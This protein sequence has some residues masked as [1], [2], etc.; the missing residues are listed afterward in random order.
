MA[1]EVLNGLDQGDPYS[2][3]CYLIYN[4]DLTKITVLK[5]GEQILLFVDDAVIIVCSKDF[6]ETHE[7]LCD[8]MQQSRGVFDW[9]KTH[10][11][12]FSVKK[13]QLLDASKKFIPNPLNPRR[14]IP[15]PQQTLTSGEQCIP[16]KETA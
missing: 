8:I 14:R 16:S 3:I 12:K 15:Q 5:A 7:K 9:A 6:N 11:C 10:N 2:G 13:F 1:F 4:S